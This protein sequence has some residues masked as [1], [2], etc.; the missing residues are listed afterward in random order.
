LRISQV[1]NWLILSLF[2]QYGF[3]MM[4]HLLKVVPVVGLLARKA[5]FRPSLN[6][7]EVDA[8][9]DVPLEMFLKVLLLTPE[10]LKLTSYWA[11]N[12]NRWIV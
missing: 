7:D 11:I 8:I 2:L 4:Q 6:T 9:F 12:V 1:Q 5:D 10:I 3:I